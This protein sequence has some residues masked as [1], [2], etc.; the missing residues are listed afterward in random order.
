MGCSAGQRGEQARGRWVGHRAGQRVAARQS[1]S[2]RKI[3]EL[4]FL[5]LEPIFSPWVTTIQRWWRARGRERVPPFYAAN[6]VLRWIFH[7]DDEDELLYSRWFQVD[8]NEWGYALLP[9]VPGGRSRPLTR[10]QED[11]TRW[12]R[13]SLTRFSLVTTYSQDREQS[14]P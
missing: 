1:R 7:D 10:T 12:M 4:Y 11:L 9:M 14:R 6:V 2:A 5:V 13:R 8:L 3:W